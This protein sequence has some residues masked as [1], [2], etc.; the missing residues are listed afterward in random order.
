MQGI[1]VSPYME[2][3]RFD[4]L[5]HSVWPRLGTHNSFQYTTACKQCWCIPVSPC[6]VNICHCRTVKIN[7]F[8]Y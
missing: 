5:N 3:Q 6:H 4:S 7:R 2:A 1:T 8:Q